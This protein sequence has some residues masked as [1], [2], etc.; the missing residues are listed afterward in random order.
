MTVDLKAQG[1]RLRIGPYFQPKAIVI[2]GIGL[3]DCPLN[4]PERPPTVM[5]AG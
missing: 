2:A 5:I 3:L 4:K 1:R